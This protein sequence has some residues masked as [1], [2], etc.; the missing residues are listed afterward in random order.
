MKTGKTKA[1]KSADPLE[2]SPVFRER[3]IET[4]PAYQSVYHVRCAFFYRPLTSR[5]A[6]GDLGPGC[7]WTRSAG[8]FGLAKQKALLKFKFAAPMRSR[9]S[10]KR[11]ESDHHLVQAIKL[12]T[13]SD[14]F[15]VR[16]ES[17]LLQKRRKSEV[18]DFGGIRL[19]FS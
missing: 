12:A 4:K 5:R 3:L 7:L 19:Q 18:T 6:A 2:V 11:S 8:K 15:G 10:G 16:S 14:R 17:E 13:L 1:R 9:E